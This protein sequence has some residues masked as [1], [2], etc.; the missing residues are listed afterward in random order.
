MVDQISGRHSPRS[1]MQNVLALRSNNVQTWRAMKRVRLHQSSPSYDDLLYTA[2]FSGNM[3]CGKSDS[4]VELCFR[5]GDTQC[6]GIIECIFAHYHHRA[7]G[8]N[9][10]ILVRLSDQIDPD[11][12]DFAAVNM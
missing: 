1:I 3:M 9:K 10:I 7:P 11:V 5:N 4:H 2:L 6:T 12:G 8:Y